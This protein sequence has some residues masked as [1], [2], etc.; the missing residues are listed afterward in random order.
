MLLRGLGVDQKGDSLDSAL[1]R[2]WPHSAVR[3]EL[4]ELFMALDDRS[5]R[6]ERALETE[7]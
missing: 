7:R 2:L 6:E 4:V 3:D 5:E 1:E